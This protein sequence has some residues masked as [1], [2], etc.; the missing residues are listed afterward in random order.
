ML[1]RILIFSV[2]GLLVI[3][4]S[5]TGLI[6]DEENTTPVKFTEISEAVWLKGIGDGDGHLAWGDYNNNGYQDL[7]IY[8]RQLFK[9]SGPPDWK[10]TDVTSEVGLKSEGS[11]GAWGDYDND[12]NLDILSFGAKETLWRNGGKPKYA[13]TDV[14][15]KSGELID[16][17]NTWGVVWLDYDRDGYLDIYLVN[18]EDGPKKF[19]DRLLHNE[20]GKFVDVTEKVG[21][22][23]EK[24]NPQ[25]GRSATIGDYN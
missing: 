6:S 20:K 12:G 9:N 24:E 10:F 7:L 14:T 11:K 1:K 23:K 16:D 8:G 13:F 17:Y 5:R 4:L 18:Y 3:S 2:I 22:G 19:P 25:P 15:A 21:L